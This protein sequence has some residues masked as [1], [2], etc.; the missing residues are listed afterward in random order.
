MICNREDAKALHPFLSK[1]KEKLGDIPTRILM[2]DDANNFYNAWKAVF[3]VGNTQKIEGN[4][5]ANRVQ[6]LI[7]QQY[8]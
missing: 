7:S 3:T 2:S 4:Q 8:P 6:I 5:S 1:I